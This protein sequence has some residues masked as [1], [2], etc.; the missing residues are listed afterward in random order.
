MLIFPAILI[1][2]AFTF[3]FLCVRDLMRNDKVYEFKGMIIKMAHDYNMRHITERGK[4]KNAHD[5]FTDKH[6]Y[7]ALL[8]SWKPLT[9]ET[10]YTEEELTKIRS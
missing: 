4:V 7:E 9:L 6:S 5:W 1:A 8:R 2:L 10:W 3:L